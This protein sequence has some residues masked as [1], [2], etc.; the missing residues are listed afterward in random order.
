MWFSI[1]LA[2]ELAEYSTVETKHR[3]CPCPSSSNPASI[4]R[5]DDHP[6]HLHRNIYRSRLAEAYCASK[7]VP[8]LGVL[9]SGIG[10]N[11]NRGIPIA[12]YAARVLRERGLERFAAPSWRQT[13]AALGR[14]SHVLPFIERY[15]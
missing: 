1:F 12:S 6:L 2:Q 7:G 13:T 14:S 4:A 5:Q 3:Q 9:S 15:H 11:L 8:G 10:T